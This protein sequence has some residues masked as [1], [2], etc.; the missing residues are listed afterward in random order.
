MPYSSPPA[1][2]GF[3]SAVLLV[4]VTPAATDEVQRQQTQL[5]DHLKR[6][7]G[8]SVRV[9]YIDASQHPA[10]VGCFSVTRFPTIVLVQRGIE[11]F[12]HEGTI[13]A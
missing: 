12:R 6:Q 10:V 1:L 8:L 5:T 11:L 3:N 9:L 13:G 7:P 2:S 4:F